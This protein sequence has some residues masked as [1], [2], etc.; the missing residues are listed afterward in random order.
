ML[1][2]D[3][4]CSN[5][6]KYYSVSDEAEI[7]TISPFDLL[8]PDRLDLMARYI[9]VRSL[10][11]G[12]GIGWGMHVY[13]SFLYSW[14]K[15][16]YDGD[17]RKSS[18]FDYI[19]NLTQLMKSIKNSGFCS[20]FGAIP[21]TGTTVV[22]GAHRLTVSLYYN[23]PVMAV[24]VQGDQQ[25]QDAEALLRI[26]MDRCIVEN[27]VN[28]YIQLD[29]SCRAAILFPYARDALDISLQQIKK[30]VRVIYAK[31]IYLNDLGKRNFI[32][33]LY[34]H[35]PWWQDA[36]YDR[37]INLRF[38]V[39]QPVRVVFFK[40]HKE[41]DLRKVKEKVRSFYGPDNGSI[42]INDTHK[43]TVWISEAVLN[44][45]ALHHLNMAP[46]FSDKIKNQIDCYNQIL[47]YKSHLSDAVC[48]DSSTVLAAYGL[49]DARDVDYISAS[50]GKI[51]EDSEDI[52]CHNDEYKDFPV[53]LE[54]IV[55]NPKCHF[56]YKGTKFMSLCMVRTFKSLRGAEKDIVDIQLIDSVEQ[57]WSRYLKDRKAVKAPFLAQIKDKAKDMRAR[58]FYS[59]V[60]IA[61]VLLPSFF[62]NGLKTTI[63]KHFSFE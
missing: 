25:V 15:D 50:G 51:C 40:P 14:N 60:T 61:R 32:N 63:K 46:P 21:Y 22:D 36:H 4:L 56:F 27:L 1:A 34:G 35:E 44:D 62:Y 42:H 41:Q 28:E 49:R 17:G 11:R 24:K 26:G 54:D 13:R 59:C 43:E 9:L 58:L 47:S 12:Y 7:E 20:N 10:D 55:T 3:L 6:L 8:H 29:N 31:N 33:L 37:F 30:D 57:K 19:H 48:I 18:F 53:N 45:N 39:D 38:K 16:F 52:G 2:K 5:V 23:C